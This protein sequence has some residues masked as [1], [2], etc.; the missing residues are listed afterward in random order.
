MQKEFTVKNPMGIHARPAGEIVKKASSFPCK[1]SFLV[2]D[3]K[4]NAKSIVGVLAAGLHHG[5]TVTVVTD[6]EKE[7]E[8]L[9]EIGALIESI[10]E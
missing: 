3:K 2:D 7:E 4:I 8:A 10:L 1:I 5:D 9:N 6:G